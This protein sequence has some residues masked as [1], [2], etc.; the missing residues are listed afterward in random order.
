MAFLI[1]VALLLLF[2][3]K[4]LT[5]IG[6]IGNTH[7]VSSA[8]NPDK[9]AIKKMVNKPELGS[10]AS[11][12]FSEMF[13]VSAF[14]MASVARAAPSISFASS[15]FKLNSK[16]FVSLMQLSSHTW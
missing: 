11:G 3:V 12:I 10:W 8:A 6:I 15:D 14:F 2:F 9:N 5:V 1:P 13:F 7:G 4:K 16:Y